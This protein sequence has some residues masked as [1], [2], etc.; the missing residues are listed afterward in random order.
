MPVRIE[1]ARVM[2]NLPGVRV[3]ALNC[4]FTTGARDAIYDGP[5]AARLHRRD[6]LRS[7][8]AAALATRLHAAPDTY[9][10]LNEFPYGAVTL[11]GGPM[12]R[13]YDAIPRIFSLSTMTG[14]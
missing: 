13:Q 2:K 9:S 10:H 8:V 4:N 6:F 14:C 5:V 11:T 1:E 7:S 12:K 3:N